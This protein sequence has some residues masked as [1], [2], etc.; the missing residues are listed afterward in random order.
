[1]RLV[2]LLVLLVGEPLRSV[3]TAGQMRTLFARFGFD[4]VQDEDIPAIAAKLSADLA[5]ATRFVK[6]LRI[7]TAVRTA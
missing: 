2:A 7:A 1:L 3:F 5:Q 6:H 4:V